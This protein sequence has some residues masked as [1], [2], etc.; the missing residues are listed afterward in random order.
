[1]GVTGCQGVFGTHE[2]P[3]DP[4]FI[5]KTPISA[6]AQYTPPV[7]LAYLEPTAPRDPYSVPAALADK[8]GRPVQGTLTNRAKEPE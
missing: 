3:H 1:L 5:S 6:K 2:P 8:N 7:T 4:L